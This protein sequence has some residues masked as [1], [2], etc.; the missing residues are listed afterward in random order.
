VHVVVGYTMSLES[1]CKRKS[2]IAS[3][4]NNNNNNNT[5]PLLVSLCSW[6]SILHTKLTWSDFLF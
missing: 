4:N 6:Y 2:I 1:D 3:N 5:Q